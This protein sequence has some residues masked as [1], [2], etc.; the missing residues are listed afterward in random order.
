MPAKE[1]TSL[2][3]MKHLI[4]ILPK[5]GAKYDK[6]K[7]VADISFIYIDVVSFYKTKIQFKYKQ[8]LLFSLIGDTLTLVLIYITVFYRMINKRNP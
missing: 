1:Y 2:P 4:D 7:A 6:E 8:V 3:I 5:N